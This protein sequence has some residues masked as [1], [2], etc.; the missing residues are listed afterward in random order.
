MYIL[1]AIIIVFLTE[2]T[3]QPFHHSY[4]APGTNESTRVKDV[5]PDGRLEVEVEVFLIHKIDFGIEVEGINVMGRFDFVIT[6]VTSISS[7]KSI[8]LVSERWS[9]RKPGRALTA[10]EKSHL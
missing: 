6:V 5:H 8:T 3:E 4:I 7:I 1:H 9:H 2:C 10:K